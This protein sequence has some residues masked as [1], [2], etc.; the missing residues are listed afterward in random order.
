MRI[1]GTIVNPNI[2]AIKN[3]VINGVLVD[4][5]GQITSM[6]SAYYVQSIAPGASVAFNALIPADDHVTYQV[7][8]QAE[9]DFK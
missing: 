3:V 7:Y 6:G 9:G 2:H 8:V 5:N 4:G 1:S